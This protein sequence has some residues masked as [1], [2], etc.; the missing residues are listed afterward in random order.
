MNIRI[1]M[2]TFM[3]SLATLGQL[4]APAMAGD[5]LVNVVEMR[6]SN[7]VVRFGL[8]NDPKTFGEKKGTLVGGKLPAKQTGVEFLFKDLKPGKYAVAVYHDENDNGDFDMGKLMFLIPMPLEGFG[9]TRDPS[10]LLG[11]PDFADAALQIDAGET[12]A[13]IK[14]KY[15][16]E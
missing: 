13:T 4:S 14:M 6:S 12:R 10:V 7:G 8:F 11:K 3:L 15:F 16:I 1:W 5:L 9:F 2:A